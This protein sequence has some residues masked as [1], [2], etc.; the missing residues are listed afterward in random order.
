MIPFKNEISIEL[1]FVN[2][3]VETGLLTDFIMNKIL[4]F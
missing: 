1:N 3:I 2:N 4:Q